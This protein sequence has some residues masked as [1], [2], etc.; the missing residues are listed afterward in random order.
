MTVKPP[1][2]RKVVGSQAWVQDDFPASAHTALLHLLHDL[3]D[4]KYVDDWIDVDKDL[5]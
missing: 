5:I 3:V 1:F 2:S 4:R